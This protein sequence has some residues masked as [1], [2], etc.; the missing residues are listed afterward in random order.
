M[1]TLQETVQHAGTAVAAVAALLVG[2]EE[3]REGGTRR[4]NNKALS[5]TP[6]RGVKFFYYSVSY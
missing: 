3:H 4:D 1:A 2:M 6:R 5:I